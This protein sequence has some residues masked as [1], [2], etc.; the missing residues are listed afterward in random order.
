M[1]LP[2]IARGTFANFDFV[3][4]N[5]EPGDSSPVHWTAVSGFKAARVAQQ[6]QLSTRGIGCRQ[7]S[8]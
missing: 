7:F 4:M 5:L 1:V 8:S 6:G 3:T 2:M